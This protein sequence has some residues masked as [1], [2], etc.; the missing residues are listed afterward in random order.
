VSEPS[1]GVR[2][3][4]PLRNDTAV[5]LEHGMS[6]L[7]ALAHGYAWYSKGRHSVFLVL[8]IGP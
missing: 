3:T 6:G 4:I 7:R 8:D 2:W 1:L 5:R